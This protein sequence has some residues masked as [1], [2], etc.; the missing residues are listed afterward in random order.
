MPFNEEMIKKSTSGEILGMTPVKWRGMIKL[1]D[2]YGEV[3]TAMISVFENGDVYFEEGK[4]IP[5]QTW[6][7]NEVAKFLTEVRTVS[8][9][10]SENITQA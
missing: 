9:P 2:G 6:V 8:V 7:K 5:A 10:S 1:R 4:F 3:T